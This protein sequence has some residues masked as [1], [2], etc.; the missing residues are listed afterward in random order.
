MSDNL[1]CCSDS[2]LECK[3]CKLKRIK[4]LAKYAIFAG[5]LLGLL[6]SSVPPK[7]QAACKSVAGILA[8]C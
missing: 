2:P 1:K 5:A 7:Y 6:C 8:A 3:D 4:K